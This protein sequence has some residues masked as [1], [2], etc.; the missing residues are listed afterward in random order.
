MTSVAGTFLK[1]Q[2]DEQKKEKEIKRNRLTKLAQVFAR[3]NSVL[4]GKK[5]A[6]HVV[7]TPNQKAPAW[8]STTEMWLNL[9]EIK[10]EINAR[11]L[12]SLQ[13]LNFH[14]L[15]HLKFT[16]RNGHKFVKWVQ[17]NNLWHS[18]NSLEDM[19]IEN[20]MVGYLPTVANW[21]VA[22]ISDYLLDDLNLIN[23]AYP[24]IVGRTY[25]PS[26]VV[27]LAT[28]EYACPDDID[29]LYDLITEYNSFIFA[30][31][32]EATLDRA[33]EVIKRY[34]ELV[35]N[36]PPMPPQG[37]D[38]GGEG[39]PTGETVI[40]LP[41]PFGHDDRPTKGYESSSV[42]PATKEEQER[43][44]QKMKEKYQNKR[45]SRKNPT[46]QDKSNDNGEGE[47]DEQGT[48]QSPKPTSSQN[49]YYNYDETDI[50]DYGSDY[51]E[52]G[53]K[54]AGSHNGTTGDNKQVTGTL[55]DVI[56]DVV[57]DLAKELNS[58]AKQLGITI[59]TLNGGN[60]Q[61]PP[62]SRHNSVSVPPQLSLVAKAFA[63]ELQRIRATHDPAWLK[64]T[65][66]G[67]LD[68]VR[69]IRGEELDTCFNEW[70]EGLDDVTDI[71][72]VILL[73]KSG[74]MS[75]TNSDNAYKSMWALKKG[76]EGVQAKATVVLF[77]HRPYLLYSS[78]EVA[79]AT[80][81]DG[82]ASG[83]T[84][85]EEAI[86]YA[87]RVLAESDKAI[88]VLFMITDGSWETEEGEKAV[89]E[90]RNA[91]V[92][93]CQA[94]L[95]QYDESTEEIEKYRHSFELLTHI[96][97]ATDILILGKQLVRL[98]ISRNLATR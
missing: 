31:A 33:K 16:P 35:K 94:Y 76:L 59:D 10:D 55:N 71:E 12:I 86:L 47:G 49:P 43:Y 17:E 50:V 61:T 6:V 41:S 60:Q 73:D 66:N 92:L 36:L 53:S 79:G 68:V 13:G 88:K 32:S 1:E 3:T 34:D 48:P 54:S 40:Y 2:T 56:N 62:R 25:L 65:D 85:P 19:R 93:T 83:G 5:I 23:R 80:I 9:P 72:A 81:R 57:K 46:S 14:E 38:I 15:S 18:F 27:Q 4:T 75:G 58:I 67:K 63:K 82:G 90:M 52:V 39:T 29:E 89:K 30:G 45:P 37:G 21:L 64:N 78:D 77:D 84:N 11:S 26:E 24:L 69:Y 22:T 91:G 20:L 98:A 97:S 74:S 96:K 44:N 70:K 87:K 7:D 42:R 51:E 28:D 95:S 8:S